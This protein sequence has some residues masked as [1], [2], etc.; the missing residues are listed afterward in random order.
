MAIKFNSGNIWFKLSDEGRF[1][2][3]ITNMSHTAIPFLLMNKRKLESV[4]ISNNQ[5]LLLNLLINHPQ[6]K[7]DTEDGIFYQKIM[8]EF[9]ITKQVSKL[10]VYKSFF[11]DKEIKSG[12]FFQYLNKNYNGLVEMINNLKQTTKIANELQKIEAEIIVNT[13]GNMDYPKLLRHDQ[14]LCHN[15]YFIDTINALNEI[16][17]SK[18]LKVKLKDKQD[19]VIVNS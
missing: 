19:K 15:E 16:Y 11:N 4:D 18:G 5:P 6:Y 7:K 3:S 12:K 10:W 8:S 9:K 17:K 13:M 2:T 1:Y 14:V